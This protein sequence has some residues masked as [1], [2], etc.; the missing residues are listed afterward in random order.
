[1]RTASRCWL[2]A[3]GSCSA[4]SEEKNRNS[5]ESKASSRYV[6][7]KRRNRREST[8]TGKKK[9]GRQEIHPGPSREIPPP[10]T[11]Q[12]RGGVKNQVRPPLWSTAK[13]PISAPRRFGSAAMV[14]KVSATA[15]N[16][17]S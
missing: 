1:F 15:R 3:S 9:R 13:K 5:P 7:N 11:T 4:A 16:K 6:K 8:R 12:W 2:K 10:G 14:V 17:M